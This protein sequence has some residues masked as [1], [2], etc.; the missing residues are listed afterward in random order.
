MSNQNMN[1][2]DILNVSKDALQYDIKFAFREK[3]RKYH[4]DKIKQTPDN[5]KMYKM[6]REAG[7]VLTDPQK[8]KAYDLEQTTPEYA[9]D[10]DI[11]KKHFDEF[12]QLQSNAVECM[13]KIKNEFETFSQSQNHA[14][15]QKIM[16]K[17]EHERRYDDMLMQREFEETELNNA[18]IFVGRQFNQNEFNK[19]FNKK[20]TSKKS[21]M[22]YDELEAYNEN[23][24]TELCAPIIN[25]EDIQNDN[26]SVSSSDELSLD[27][28]ENDEVKQQ[29]VDAV[30]QSVLD[31]RKNQDEIIKKLKDSE[32][33]SP[34]DDKFGVSHGIGLLVGN[35]MHGKQISNKKHNH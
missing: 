32:Y 24:Q 1:Y 31:E 19:M 9:K 10:I 22:K 12:I 35:S 3:L 34:L 6:I 20:K 14:Q 11:Y 7:D 30:A 27:S 26:D 33:G 16:T 8:R 28:V 13:N 25:N 29:N 18:N 4:P 17:D 23:G 15:H 5:I 21:D 2:Y